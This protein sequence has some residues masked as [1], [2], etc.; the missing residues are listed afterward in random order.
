MAENF[1]RV[2]SSD[3]YRVLAVAA[4][5][6][7]VEIDVLVSEGLNAVYWVKIGTYCV[8]GC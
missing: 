4:E 7:D 8:R 2:A 5:A 3:L 6:C 1:R